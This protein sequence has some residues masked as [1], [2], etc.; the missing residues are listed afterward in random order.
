MNAC[1]VP[2]K[3][4]SRSESEIIFPDPPTVFRPEPPDEFFTAVETADTDK[5]PTEVLL[6]AAVVT[7]L[8]ALFAPPPNNEKFP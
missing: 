7:L 3:K 2:A 5:W 1:H 8:A 6:A 4:V